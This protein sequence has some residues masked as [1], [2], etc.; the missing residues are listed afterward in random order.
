MK[1]L[2]AS[3]LLG[4]LTAAGMTLA[5]TSENGLKVT[6]ARTLTNELRETIKANKAMLVEYLQRLA[7]ND[8]LA[9]ATAN[10]ERWNWPHSEAMNE[11]E[12]NTFT[13]RL[14]RFT[15]KRASLEVAERLADKLVIRD[16]EGDDR[17]LCLECVYLQSN[18]HWRCFNSRV[19]D[20]APEGLA[21]ELV[22]SLQRC[23][24]FRGPDHPTL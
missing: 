16:R 9:E 12:I 11:V 24:G 8:T 4:T 14:A 10:P 18:G 3:D 2:C 5:L 13:E 17:R 6:P 15:D 1:P 21:S 20:V 23:C 22:F 7:A 19:A